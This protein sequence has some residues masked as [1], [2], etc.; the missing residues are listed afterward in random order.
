[1]SLWTQRAL[2]ALILGT[3]IL[4]RFSDLERMEFKGDEAVAIHLAMPMVEGRELP[5]VGLRSSVGVHNPPLFIYLVAGPTLISVDAVWVTGALV[6]S[7]SI[8]ALLLSFVWLRKRFGAATALITTALYGCATWPVL[9]ARKLW[10]QDV[11]PIFSV[12]LLWILCRIY[13]KP[14]TRW[15]A[16]IP[17]LLCALW[18]LHFSAFAV[19]LVAIV[20][21][22]FRFR[23]LHLPALAAG[24]A[25]ALL[26][27][28]P[29][30]QHQLRHDYEDLHGLANMAKGVRA[31]GSVREKPKTFSD[32]ALAWTLYVASGTELDYSLGADTDAYLASLG[33]T[34]AGYQK[35][36]S[37]VGMLL[38]L[39]GLG[40]MT[41]RIGLRLY[42]RRRGADTDDLDPGDAHRRLLIGWIVGYVAIYVLVRLENIYPHYFIILYPVPFLLMALPL[43]ELLRRFPRRGP[44]AAVLI[45]LFIVGSHLSTL[46]SLQSFLQSRG[47]AS[48]DYGVLYEHKEALTEWAV[49]NG[50]TLERPPG[51]EFGHLMR[52]TEQYGDLDA[53]HAAAESR[54][55]PPANQRRVH[56]YDTL[57]FPRATDFRCAGRQDFGPLVTCPVR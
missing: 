29:Y 50:L 10:A 5:R 45:T 7:L 32:D 15:V 33:R 8:L 34:R 14:R 40:L 2:L 17:I 20:A 57:R 6:G 43:R 3:A 56:V 38:F 54:P 16:A 19:I 4:L 35:L 42:R 28:V 18:Q 44:F 41:G 55:P 49:G 46:H 30:A 11:L 26:M 21:T 36:G 23:T 51:W 12:T 48:G 13:E 22:L 37:M 39:L 47:G 53:I 25:V 27:L 1:M 31:D 24:V 9:Y 52:M